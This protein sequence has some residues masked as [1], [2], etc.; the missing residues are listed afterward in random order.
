VR[1]KISFYMFYFIWN[2]ESVT[3][4]PPCN[5]STFIQAEFG[6]IKFAAHVSQVQNVI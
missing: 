6:L 1:A 4:N 3:L 2:R 5:I